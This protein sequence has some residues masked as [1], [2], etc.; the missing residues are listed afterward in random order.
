MIVP[1][2]IHLQ[3][4]ALN[5]QAFAPY[6]EV[7]DR[8]QGLAADMNDAR[9]AR[10]QGLARVSH[11]ADA[12]AVISIAECLTPSQLPYAIR[13]ME[14]HP[15]SSQAFIPLAQTPFY[16]VVAP[17]GEAPE[18]DALQAF[19]SDGTQGIN[20]FAGTWHMPLIALHAGQRFLV[21]D[22]EESRPNCDEFELT[23]NVWL[24]S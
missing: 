11:A 21:V 5:R 10:Y 9:F 15:H 12:A 13:L 6:G 16:V 3:A 17:P 14:R 19:V 23:A 7:I 24:A 20:Y 22:A 8:A 1:G 4:R 2:A 18:A